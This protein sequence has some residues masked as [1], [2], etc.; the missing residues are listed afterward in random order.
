LGYDAMEALPEDLFVDSLDK[1]VDFVYDEGNALK[2]PSTISSRLILAPLNE[3][4][5]EVNRKIQTLLGTEERVY[6]SSDTPIGSKT[7]DP[8]YMAEHQV[9]VLNQKHISGFPPH[10]LE[11]YI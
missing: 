11:V 8:Y 10:K 9:E 4:V 2:D 7:F 1:L 3:D 5:S 6:L